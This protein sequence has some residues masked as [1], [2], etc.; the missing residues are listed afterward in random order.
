M[1]VGL[2]M[3][4]MVLFLWTVTIPIALIWFFADKILVKIVPDKEVASL[5]GLY[6]KVVL[7]GSPGYALFES[8]KR[9]LQAQGLFSASL[10][11]LLVY[12][13]FSD[14]WCHFA[15]DG[16]LDMFFCSAHRLMRL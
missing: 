15:D 5:A 8:G 7:L 11:V 13:F 2:Q 6:L 4:K 16:P 1:L 10:Y 12:S 9:F 3:Q 14:G